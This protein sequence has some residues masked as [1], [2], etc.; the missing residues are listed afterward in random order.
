MARKL[1]ELVFAFDYP[2]FCPTFSKACTKLHQRAVP[3]QMR[4]TGP[5]IDRARALRSLL[6]VQQRGTWIQAKSVLRYDKHAV[7]A[8]VHR[9]LPAALQLHGKACEEVLAD[10]FLHARTL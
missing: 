1:D 7:L 9:D 4:H 10:M 8:R 3:Y 5:S 6:E 2:T